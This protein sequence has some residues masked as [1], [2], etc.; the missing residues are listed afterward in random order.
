MN[1]ENPESTIRSDV[2]EPVKANQIS[3]DSIMDWMQ[4]KVSIEVSRGWLVA[5]GVAVLLLLLLAVD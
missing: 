4:K 2:K 1:T 5:A 3:L